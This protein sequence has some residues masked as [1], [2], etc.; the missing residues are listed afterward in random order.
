MPE[1][2][3]LYPVWTLKRCKYVVRGRDLGGKLEPGELIVE[4]WLCGD[5]D[6]CG[7]RDRFGDWEAVFFVFEHFLL[8]SGFAS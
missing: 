6:S 1:D 2:S 8:Q 3:R 4:W 5:G 7:G